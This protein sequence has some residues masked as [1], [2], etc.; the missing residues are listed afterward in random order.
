MNQ[1]VRMGVM[2][3]LLLAIGLY[4][5]LSGSDETPAPAPPPATKAPAPPKTR[6]APPPLPPPMKRAPKAAP[7]PAPPAPIDAAGAED[8]PDA[9]A[10][11]GP[12]T[13]SLGEHT[14][15]LKGEGRRLLTVGIELTMDSARGADEVR[16]RR[17][18]LVRMLFFLCANRQA[19]GTIGA[20]GEARLKAD[21]ESRFGN[22]I[23]SGTIR[24][25]EFTRFEVSSPAA[26]DAGP[27]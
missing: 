22:A 10:P 27:E 1:M 16:R 12:H 2:F 26:T 14:I 11:Q 4:G 9:E 3:A 7:T 18:Q 5:A 13:Y 8:V 17:R 21:L 19:A 20:D 23:K 24:S 6:K 15:L 25:L